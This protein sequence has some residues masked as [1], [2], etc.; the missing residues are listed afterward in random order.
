MGQQF[1][2][3]LKSLQTNFMDMGINVSEQI[4][5]ST[6]SFIDHDKQLAQQVIDHDR[7][8]NGSEVSL[9]KQALYLMALQQPVATNFREIVSI[10][11]A[12]ADLERIGDHAVGI[13]RE[14]IYIKGNQ[15]IPE[16]E[17]MIAAMTNSVRKMLE[18]ALDAYFR[19]NVSV[20]EKV[21]ATDHEI[22]QQYVQIRQALTNSPQLDSEL[23]PASASY[24]MVARFLE[25]IG[26]HIVN[27][28]EW[29]VY[30]KTGNIVELGNHRRD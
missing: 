21:A 17:E 30:S 18:E 3:E 14:T 7:M 24:L 16:V 9:E 5:Q 8:I 23:A 27:I 19:E 26:D 13:A 22:D 1:F 15:R 2:D 28:S 10:L 6:K 11:K 25:R 29:I 12:S 20:A 4:Y